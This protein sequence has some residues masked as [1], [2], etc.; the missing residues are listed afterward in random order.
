[1]VIDRLLVLKAKCPAELMF[2]NIDL[3]SELT[4]HI[5]NTSLRYAQVMFY[6]PTIAWDHLQ[7]F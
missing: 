7:W 5:Q 6:D 2:Y 1:M 3:D 4:R